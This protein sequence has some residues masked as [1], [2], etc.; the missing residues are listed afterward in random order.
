M[1]GFFIFN[2]GNSLDYGLRVTNSPATSFPTRIVESYQ[3]PGRSGNLTFDTGAYGNASQTYE[4]W[5]RNKDASSYE[6]EA[7]LADWLMKPKG[8]QIL[9]DSYF[10]DVFRKAL[11]VGSAEIESF[12]EK[13]GRIP[14]EFDCMPQKWLKN[15]QYFLTIGNGMQVY[16]E[17]EPALPLFQI[18]GAGSGTLTVGEYSMEIS[19]IP[20]TGLTID[21]DLQNAYSGTQNCNSLLSAD[22]FPKL[23]P[24]TTE[25]SF[26][27]GISEVKMKPRWWK[28]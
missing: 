11:Y 19:E 4:C 1:A 5:Y 15:G 28:L 13:Y 18:S 2:G 3:V 6:L 24:G 10:P 23:Q 22:E 21:C 26:S 9:E 25:I 12:W 20:A 16:N 7:F 14:I 27:G 17:W 8:Y